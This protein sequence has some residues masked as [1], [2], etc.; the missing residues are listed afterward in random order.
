MI[1]RLGFLLV[2][3]C[4]VSAFAQPGINKWSI[5]GELLLPSSKAN[6]AFRSFMNGLLV[7]QPKV[8]FQPTKHWF[9]SAGPRYMYYTVSE[10]KVPQKMNG[11]IHIVGGGLEVGYSTWQGKRFAVEF[12]MKVGA[13]HYMFRTDSTRT[14]GNRQLTAM[15]YE[16]NVQFVLMADEAVAYR[17]IMGYNF[18]GY[19]FRPDMV[20]STWGGYKLQDL[21]A[22][23]Q[24]IVIGFGITYYLGNKR[25]DTD[26]D[27]SIFRE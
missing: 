8:T 25:S 3:M 10:F 1:K 5:G 22:S 11:G 26:L 4:S 23:T 13:A 24:S 16:P 27:E 2:L 19:A 9:L 21:G 6:P 7:A 15:Y 14:L 12:G 17:W 20:Q 18:A